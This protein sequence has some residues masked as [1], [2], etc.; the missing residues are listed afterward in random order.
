MLPFVQIDGGFKL[1]K[2]IQPLGG[3]ERLN[4]VLI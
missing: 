4:E 2:A 1:F 3:T